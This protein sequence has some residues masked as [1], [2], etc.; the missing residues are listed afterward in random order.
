MLS[1]LQR[2]Q[3]SKYNARAGARTFE[4]MLERHNADRETQSSTNQGREL[5]VGGGWGA[6][7]FPALGRATRAGGVLE[8][9]GSP[10][11]RS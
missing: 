5:G 8:G 6:S 1:P 4:K 9:L 3:P 7:L 11:P 2:K 10:R